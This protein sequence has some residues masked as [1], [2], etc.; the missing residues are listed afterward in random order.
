MHVTL[1]SANGESEESEGVTLGWV[2]DGETLGTVCEGKYVVLNPDWG[3]GRFYG[4][5]WEY[6]ETGVKQDG[7]RD[8]KDLASHNP[9]IINVPLS[10]A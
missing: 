3:W 2:G 8:R 9:T 4:D 5:F 1:N 6:N 10:R 7:Q